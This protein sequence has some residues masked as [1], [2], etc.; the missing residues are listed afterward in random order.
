MTH[1]KPP[2]FFNLVNANTALFKVCFK[3]TLY[4]CCVYACNDITIYVAAIT[5]QPTY[6]AVETGSGVAFDKTV[7]Y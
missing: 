4:E 3:L 7:L 5:N 1:H 6:P 2:N